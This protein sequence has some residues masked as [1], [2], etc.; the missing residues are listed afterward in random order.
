[1]DT[2]TTILQADYREQAA[3]I[4]AIRFAVFVEEQDVPPDIEMDDR[5]PLCIHLLAYVDDQ[6]VGTV[7]I[8]FEHTAK[9]GRLAVL[10]KC[11]RQGIG[12]ALMQR[13]H[14]IA[15]QRHLTQVWCNAQTAAVP[16][17][18]SIGYS[19][20]GHEFEEAGIN[21]VRMTLALE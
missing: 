3:T 13:C 5:D 4:R 8:D 19:V 14:E 10:A 20:T 6:P 1:L 21:H 2:G 11:R 16:F 17:Y 7:R 12:R 15:R 18:K 9:I